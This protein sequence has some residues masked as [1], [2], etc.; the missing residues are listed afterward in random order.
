MVWSRWTL[1]LVPQFRLPFAFVAVTAAFVIAA[2]FPIS[3]EIRRDAL[4]ISFVGAVVVIGFAFVPAVQVGVALLLAQAIVCTVQ[5]RQAATKVAFNLANEALAS[6]VAGFV[7]SVVLRGASP[8]SPRGWL[9][10][11]CAYAAL[12]T[13]EFSAIVAVITLA[14]GRRVK[15]A[16]MAFAAAMTTALGTAIAVLFIVVR[17][18][19]ARA[20]VIFLLPTISVAVAGRAHHSLRQRYANLGLLYGFTRRVAGL[21]DLEEML[22]AVLREAREL[23]RAEVAEAT[24]VLPTR[25]VTASVREGS[26]EMT[27]ITG[28]RALEHLVLD[29]NAN[30]LVPRGRAPEELRQLLDERSM[31]D[32]IAV[33]LPGMTDA[34]GVLLVANRL[35]TMSTFEGDDL[36]LLTALASHAAAAFQ[37]SELLERLREEAAAKEHQALHDALT[38][39]PNRTLFAQRLSSAIDTVTEGGAVGV[40]LMDLD[41]FKV[42]NDTLGHHIGDIVLQ[43]S[44]ARLRAVTPP[45][46]TVARLGGDEFAVILDAVGGPQEVAFAAHVLRTALE[47]PLLV[48]E[49]TLEVGASIGIAVAPLHG[50]DANMLLQRADIAMYEAKGSQT[51][52]E[53]YAPERDVLNARRLALVGELRQAIEA[54]A[55]DLWFQPQ[56]DLA[57]G[58]VIAVEAL[59][60]WS[61]PRYGFVPPDEFIPI[62]EQSGLIRPLTLWVVRHAVAQAAAWSAAGRPIGVAVNLSARNLLDAELAENLAQTLAAAG[63]PAESLT[64]EITES[65]MMADPTRSIDVLGQLSAMGARLSVDDFGTGYSSLSRLKRLPV[66][67]VKI[68]RS[69]VMQMCT[70]DYDDAIVRSTIELA[71]NLRLVVVAEGVEDEATW[72]RLAALGCDVAQGYFLAKPMPAPELDRCLAQLCA[73]GVDADVDGDA[74]RRANTTVALLQRAL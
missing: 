13:V 10:A 27:V 6:G 41:G 55:L 71:H 30:L 64:L 38:G 20:L 11:L 53:L 72:E 25:V 3:F 45:T 46:G 24:V 62:A 51:G 5:E 42:I 14:T 31:N 60:R 52:V 65:H 43:E 19:D 57:T 63:V 74:E 32:L 7:F 68:D 15:S 36:K 56:A 49:L 48:E 58:E 29:A 8:A 70:D 34:A 37:N 18:A 54:D 35:S 22:P 66:D 39:L 28:M 12:S 44:A 59:L 9:A 47:Q 50:L 16:P 33:P 21:R 69:F 23:L 67:E 26:E 2:V 17:V 40:L 73:R 4:V 1:H 61:H